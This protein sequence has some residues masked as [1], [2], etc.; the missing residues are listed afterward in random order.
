M[1]RVILLLLL[2][3]FCSPNAQAEMCSWVDAK[4]VRHFSNAG[5]PTNQVERTWKEIERAVTDEVSEP[6]L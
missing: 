1:M 2:F 5:S 3:L 4:G 6:C